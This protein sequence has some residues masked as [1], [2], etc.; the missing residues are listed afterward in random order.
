M[1][2]ANGISGHATPVR[3]SLS[4]GHWSRKE[5]RQVEQTWVLL[6]GAEI[7]QTPA[8]TAGQK[9]NQCSLLSATRCEVIYYTSYFGNS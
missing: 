5:E 3:R 8:S 2:I 6:S 9:R 1:I 7:T 4:G